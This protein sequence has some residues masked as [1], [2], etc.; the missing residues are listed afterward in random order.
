MPVQRTDSAITEA[1]QPLTTTEILR[2]RHRLQSG[3][4]KASVFRPQRSFQGTGTMTD[5]TTEHRDINAEVIETVAAMVQRDPAAS[6]MQH[7][8][9]FNDAMQG[10]GRP[11]SNVAGPGARSVGT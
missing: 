4:A 3:A 9:V 8:S 10:G 5:R 1:S 6:N 7:L 11:L 2:P